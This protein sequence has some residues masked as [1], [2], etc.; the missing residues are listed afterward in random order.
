MAST[1]FHKLLASTDRLAPVGER[2]LLL[3]RNVGA[4][5]SEFTLDGDSAGIVRTGRYGVERC[6]TL[7]VRVMMIV[8][9]VTIPVVNPSGRRINQPCGI[10]LADSLRQLDLWIIV[11]QLTPTFVIDYLR[12]SV[13]DRGIML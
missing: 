10:Q 2:D 5:T 11:R 4:D 7:W 3:N 8:A 6:A 1:L 12:L 13:K 9:E